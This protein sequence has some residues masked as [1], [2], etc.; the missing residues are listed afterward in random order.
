MQHAE[1]SVPRTNRIECRR[2][3]HH[4][5][6]WS[7]VGPDGDQYVSHLTAMVP[8]EEE[9]LRAIQDPCPMSCPYKLTNFPWNQN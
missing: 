3:N 4:W 8:E 7:Q 9:I 6:F 2:E 5:T 1:R